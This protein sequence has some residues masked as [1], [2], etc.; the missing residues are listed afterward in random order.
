MSTRVM[1]KKNIIYV[2]DFLVNCGGVIDLDC[3]GKIY[4]E[5]YVYKRWNR[6]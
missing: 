1:Y 3:E 6:V 5:E 2:P 4:S